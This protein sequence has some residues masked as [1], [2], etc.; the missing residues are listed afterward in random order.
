VQRSAYFREFQRFR[1][2][3]IV[4]QQRDKEYGDSVLAI[5]DDRA[6]RDSDNLVTIKHVEA[7]D[8]EEAAIRW[9]YSDQLL[10]DDPDQCA[11]HAI[12]CPTNKSVDAINS[13]ILERLPG[14]A[15]VLRGRTVMRDDPYGNANPFASP[16]LLDGL[17]HSGVPPTYLTLKVGALCMTVRNLSSQ[18]KLMNATRV[19]STA[20]CISYFRRSAL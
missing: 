12:L 8:A 20:F 13:G 15:S 18:N 1:L 2:T 11:K 17:K 16:E 6:P 10:V 19:V 4:R 3:E 9:V 14:D 7:T 5:G